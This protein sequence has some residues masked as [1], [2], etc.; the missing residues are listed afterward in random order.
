M[1]TSAIHSIPTVIASTVAI[2]LFKEIK[3]RRKYEG[4]LETS[5]QELRSIVDSISKQTESKITET[6]ERYLALLTQLRTDFEQQ[7]ESA[8]GSKSTALTKHID[9]IDDTISQ[10]VEILVRS[11]ANQGRHIEEAIQQQNARLENLSSNQIDENARA[12]FKSLENEFQS[13]LDSFSSLVQQL[14]DQIQREIASERATFLEALCLCAFSKPNLDAGDGSQEILLCEL[15]RLQTSDAILMLNAEKYKQIDVARVLSLIARAKSSDGGEIDVFDLATAW[16]ERLIQSEQIVTARE[17]GL[18]LL[19]SCP[20]FKPVTRIDQQKLLALY[21]KVAGLCKEE[22]FFAD[23]LAEQLK[24]YLLNYGRKQKAADTSQLLS[25]FDDI[26]ELTPSKSSK[27]RE[28]VKAALEPDQFVDPLVR[29]VN[30]LTESGF[31]EKAKL[32][33]EEA[34]RIAESDDDDGRFSRLT[35]LFANIEI[36]QVHYANAEALYRHL[37]NWQER[38]QIAD[39]SNTYFNLGNVLSLQKNYHEAELVLKKAMDSIELHYGNDHEKLLPVLMQL[40]SLCMSN[41]RY[42]DAEPFY[43]RI[44]EIK[45]KT[46]GEHSDETVIALTNLGEL[47]MIQKDFVEAEIFLESALEAAYVAYAPDDSRLVQIA[48]NYANL[49]STLGRTTP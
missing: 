47:Y 24:S 31:Y 37:A 21:E 25:I 44:L 23:R 26:Y 15:L 36:R 48:N 33:L 41:Q 13:K 6:N 22:D 35:V 7:L 12:Q 32:L 11:V 42:K 40:A 8:A 1:D 45:H 43:K 29:E 4:S 27:Y 19:E 34:L 38:K 2:L 28:Q 39:V 3:R 16:I 46:H 49:L 30:E 18:R 9:D 20:E 10:K 5:L 17:I 14:I